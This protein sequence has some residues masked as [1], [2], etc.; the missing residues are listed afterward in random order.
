M[1]FFAVVVASIAH[2]FAAMENTRS[3]NDY[4]REAASVAVEVAK[5]KATEDNRPYEEWIECFYIVVDT[6]ISRE[7]FSAEDMQK[8]YNTQLIAENHYPSF[9]EMVKQSFY[10]LYALQ[11]ILANIPEQILLQKAETGE[12]QAATRKAMV[13]FRPMIN[14]AVENCYFT[15]SRLKSVLDLHKQLEAASPPHLTIDAGAGQERFDPEAALCVMAELYA[16]IIN[17]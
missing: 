17:A 9:I 10:R 3:L 6:A 4:C 14:A 15:A 5:T 13:D 7:C 8:T 2:L 12:V 16:A 11:S 1:H